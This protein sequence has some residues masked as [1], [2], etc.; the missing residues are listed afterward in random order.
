[1]QKASVNIQKNPPGEETQHH[2]YSSPRRVSATTMGRRGWD[3][4]PTTVSFAEGLSHGAK[5]CVQVGSPA[6][7]GPGSHLSDNDHGGPCCPQPGQQ[8]VP[9]GP[10]RAWEGGSGQQGLPQASAQHCETQ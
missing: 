10:C 9:Q 1:M 5:Q 6:E 8:Q 2:M 3:L 7:L 4:E